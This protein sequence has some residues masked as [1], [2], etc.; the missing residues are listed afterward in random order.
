M[1]VWTYWENSIKT[2]RVPPLIELCLETMKT[3]LKSCNLVILD[4]SNIGEYI[5]IEYD[6]DKLKL[7]RFPKYVSKIIA[8]TSYYRIKLLKE[9]GGVWFDADTILIKDLDYIKELLTKYDFVCSRGNEV[10]KICNGFFAANKNTKIIN[11]ILD[12]QRKKINRGYLKRFEIGTHLLSSIISKNFKK[13]YKMDIGTIYPMH[14]RRVG[15]FF[16]YNNVNDYINQYTFGWLLFRSLMVENF[17]SQLISK[18]RI[19]QSNNLLGQMFNKALNSENKG[20]KN[21]YSCSRCRWISGS[22]ISIKTSRKGS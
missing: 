14:T 11:H 15:E 19:L 9:Y 13:Y 20:D 12:Q 10:S 2:K 17:G 22:C 21:E 8:K 1:Y 6:F 16:G 7:Y 5:D 3:H 4:E 18:R